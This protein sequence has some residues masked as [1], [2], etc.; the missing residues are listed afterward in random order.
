MTL[1]GVFVIAFLLGAVVERATSR[2]RALERSERNERVA[3]ALVEELVRLRSTVSKWATA[4]PLARR[5]V[6]QNRD[7]IQ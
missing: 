4:A 2:G 7:R 6:S 3:F 1:L 5:H